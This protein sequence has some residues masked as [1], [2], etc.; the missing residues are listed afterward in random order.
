MP[1]MRGLKDR[2]DFDNVYRLGRRVRS[3]GLSVV[4]HVKGSA[5]PQLGLVVPGPVGT[6]VAR[7]KLKRRLKEAIRA[8]RPQMGANVIIRAHRSAAE[9]SFAELH[10]HLFRCLEQAG[11]ARDRPA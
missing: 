10:A 8:Y 7:N 5:P 9:A 6:A 3:D 1:A 2:R 11:V 4:A